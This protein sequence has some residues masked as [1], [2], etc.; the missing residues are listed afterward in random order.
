MIV[1]QMRG[2]DMDRRARSSSLGLRTL[3]GRVE[4]EAVGIET[5]QDK[6][7][8]EGKATRAGAGTGE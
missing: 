2:A 4:S 5:E 3:H 8:S 1:E 7:G 6:E